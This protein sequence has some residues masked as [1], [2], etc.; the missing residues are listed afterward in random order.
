MQLCCDTIKQE[1]NT[2][3]RIS[4]KVVVLKKTHMPYYADFQIKTPFHKFKYPK[5][6]IEVEEK[7][8]V[9]CVAQKTKRMALSDVLIFVFF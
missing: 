1:F 8:V 4:V 7:A 3:F 5:M 2:L 6:T 9:L